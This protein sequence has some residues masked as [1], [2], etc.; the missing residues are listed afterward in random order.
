MI[1]FFALLY[2]GGSGGTGGGVQLTPLFIVKGQSPPPYFCRIITNFL[3]FYHGQ[4]III[5]TILESS[6][7]CLVV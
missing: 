2:G 1:A 5:R 4:L 7:K 3:S 6:S